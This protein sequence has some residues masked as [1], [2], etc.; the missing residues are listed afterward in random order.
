MCPATKDVLKCDFLT[1]KTH[2][3]SLQNEDIIEGFDLK[4]IAEESYEA[5]IFCLL[6]EYLP[7]PKLRLKAVQK[8]IKVLQV[9]GI[10][11][12]V[13][14]DSNPENKN[15]SQMKSWR[16]AMAHLGLIRIYIE[17]LRHVHCLA[18]V[19]VPLPNYE[20]ALEQEILSIQRK[21][22]ADSFELEKAF[23]IPQD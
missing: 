4:S 1:V 5:V 2:L 8:A 6:L 21:Y 15:Q 22:K 16:L 23:Y 18:F 19:K 14:P 11:V 9:G 7:T 3:S 10:L 12:I 13:T 20:K 17:K